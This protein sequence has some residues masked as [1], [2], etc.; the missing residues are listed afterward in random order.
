MLVFDGRPIHG[1]GAWAARALLYRVLKTRIYSI[2]VETCVLPELTT[3]VRIVRGV[4]F[5]FLDR[6]YALM[7]PIAR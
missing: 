7:A 6:V 2:T 3:I 4:F 5:V 1:V